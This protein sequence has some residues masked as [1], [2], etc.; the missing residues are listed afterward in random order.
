MQR[1]LKDWMKQLRYQN[2]FI[3]LSKLFYSLKKRVQIPRMCIKLLLLNDN[4]KFKRFK[5]WWWSYAAQSFFFFLNCCPKHSSNHTRIS[6]KS[7]SFNTIKDP[8]IP[9]SPRMCIKLLLKNYNMKFKWSKE[10]WWRRY[11]AQSILFWLNCYPKHS[12][13]HTRISTKTV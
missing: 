6:T 9:L 10:W 11:A 4:M 3:Y 5:K 7:V 13:N 2:T 8:T 12:S 1:S